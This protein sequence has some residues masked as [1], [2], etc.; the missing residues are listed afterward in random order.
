MRSGLRHIRPVRGGHIHKAADAARRVTLYVKKP[1]NIGSSWSV[2]PVD[3]E[4]SSLNL[5]WPAVA[6]ARVS[7][8]SSS[9]RSEGAEGKGVCE[10][11]GEGGSVRRTC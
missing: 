1:A 7:R 11:E 8:S 2:T 6:Q 3:S 9:Q 5:E 10:G 4:A